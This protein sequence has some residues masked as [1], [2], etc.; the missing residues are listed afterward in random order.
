MAVRMH[1]QEGVPPFE[2][3]TGGFVLKTP[4]C[5]MALADDVIAQINFTPGRNGV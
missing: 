5:R 1:G 3:E 2:R 4:F